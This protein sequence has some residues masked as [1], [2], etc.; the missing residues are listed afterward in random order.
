MSVEYV[1]IVCGE[2]GKKGAVDEHHHVG[3]S[4]TF[5]VDD[6]RNVVG[7]ELK[8]RR[9]QIAKPQQAVKAGRK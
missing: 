4:G 8:R 9:R 2:C 3:E 5:Y 1:G 6:R 7:E